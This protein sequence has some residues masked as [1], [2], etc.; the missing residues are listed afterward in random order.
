MKFRSVTSG[1]FRQ[2][3]QIARIV[4]LFCLVAVGFSSSGFG[5]RDVQKIDPSDSKKLIKQA[6]KLSRDG[7]ITKA[8]E[9]LA[10]VLLRNPENSRAKLELAY[11]KLKRRDLRV[12][13]DYSYEVAK[14]EPDNSF[15]FAI[16]GATYLSAGN[17]ETARELLKN[18]LVLNRREA[19]AWAAT[20]MLDFYENRIDESISNLKEAVHHDS[21]EPD[22]EFA[23]AQV[24]SRGEKYR[25]AARAYQRFL[26]ISPRTDVERRERIK[27]LIRFLTYLGKKSSLYDLGGESQTSVKMK[28]VNNRPMVE[29]RLNRDGEPLNFV[30]DTGSGIT[31]IS[32]K[33]ANRMNIKPVTRGGEARAL[34]GDGK[35]DIVYGFIN[36]I[37][38]GDVKIRNVPVYIREFHNTNE[39]VDGYVGLSLISHYVATIDYG[40]RTFSLIKKGSDAAKAIEPGGMALPLRLTSSGFLSGEV[41]LEGIETPLNFIVDTGASI[42][43]ISQDLAGTREMSPYDSGEKMRVIGAAGITENVPSFLLPR[44]TFGKYSR[45]SLRAIALDLDLINET[46]GFEQS[47]IL[48][49]N[50]LR[51]YRLTFDF[52]KSRLTFT[53]NNK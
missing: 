31:V 49:G 43:V 29:L 8:E 24:S 44:V 35:F 19:L 48:G 11:L 18:A 46:S 51:N 6:K 37:Y 45:S 9:I 21:R 25:E 4:L 3:R 20:G 17:F 2:P 15:A 10:G 16:L 36:N 12:A 32:E 13:Y 41:K 40:K 1:H 30:L 22:F 38:L 34:G 52:Q 23:L 42:S 26:R 28:V 5:A 39:R 47:G 7:N 53:P 50:F 27:G 33:T 14:K